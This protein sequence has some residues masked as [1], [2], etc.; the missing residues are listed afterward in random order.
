MEPADPDISNMPADRRDFVRGTFGALINDYLASGQFKT[1]KPR[2]KA[3]YSR[4]CE[5]LQIA[6]GSKRVAHMER[7]HVRQIRDEKADTPG[8]ANNVLRMVKILLN[9]AV[10]DGLIQ[11]SP[12]AKFKELPLGE[13]RDWTD[14]EC[15][16][17]EQRWVPGTMQRRAYA[18]ALY[19]GQRKT[20]L[21]TRER[22]HRRDGGIAVVQSKTDEPLWIPEHRE[23]TAELG[24]GVAGISYLLT[25]PTQ[26]KQFD[27]VYFGSWFA[28]AIHKA[29]LPDDCVL[30]GLRKTAARKL[31]DLGCS[32]ET[33]KAVTG[34]ATT[35]MVA[36]YVKGANQK[37]LASEAMKR[38]ENSG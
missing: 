23:L 14:D 10:D 7:R 8:E 37:R 34:H 36:K 1:K 4:L 16:K 29:G 9:F 5:A 35:R 26:G 25:T 28:D 11:A 20:D 3:S 15:A 19:T 6:H 13:W 24:R 32:E 30:H 18:L 22:S 2:T 21:V 17:F 31:A 38:W 33:I 12:A 27:P